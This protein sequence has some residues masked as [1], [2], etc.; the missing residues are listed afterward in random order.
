[1]IYLLSVPVTTKQIYHVNELW[2]MNWTPS[3][4]DFMLYDALQP[5]LDSIEQKPSMIFKVLGNWAP[6]ESIQNH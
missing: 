5:V 1:M 3:C 6:V 2:H 4:M